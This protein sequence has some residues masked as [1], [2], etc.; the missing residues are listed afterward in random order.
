MPTDPGELCICVLSSDRFEGCTQ[1]EGREH[2]QQEANRDRESRFVRRLSSVDSW[3]T[4][5]Q[6]AVRLGEVA[7]LISGSARHCVLIARVDVDARVDVEGGNEACRVVS[8]RRAVL[9]ES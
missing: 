8:S 2:D 1:D 4:C 5:V 9:Q 3:G 6:H 7:A